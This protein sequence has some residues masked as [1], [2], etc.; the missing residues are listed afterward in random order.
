MQL[1]G[2]SFNL[3]LGNLRLRISIGLD[4]RDVERP[5]TRVEDMPRFEIG[6]AERSSKLD[7]SVENRGPWRGGRYRT[8]CQ[9]MISACQPLAKVMIPSPF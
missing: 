8:T 3:D 5:G 2:T 6:K 7:R 4:E 9:S 1:F